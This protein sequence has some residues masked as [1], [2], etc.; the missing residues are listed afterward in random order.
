MS[1][2][3]HS[4]DKVSITWIL[5]LT[6]T[7]SLLSP[8]NT[9]AKRLG[10]LEFLF[11]TQ[12]HQWLSPSW[13]KLLWFSTNLWQVTFE[14]RECPPAPFWPSPHWRPTSKVSTWGETLW[15]SA[16]TNP[17]RNR[18]VLKSIIIVL[19]PQQMPT[20][21]RSKLICHQDQSSKLSAWLKQNSR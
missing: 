8:G 19:L 15:Y 6:T 7:K 17:H 21:Y 16:T 4:C 1:F 12:R 20:S 3:A 14:E 18:R 11:F 2:A 13:Y 9:L 10:P 5:I